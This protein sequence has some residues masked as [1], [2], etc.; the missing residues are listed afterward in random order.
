MAHVGLLAAVVLAWAVIFDMASALLR[1]RSSG[2]YA[3]LV[4]TILLVVLF[5][6]GIRMLGLVGRQHAQIQEMRARNLQAELDLLKAQVHPHFLFNTLN[7]L[8]GLAR[9]GAPAAADG[10]AQLRTCCAT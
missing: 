9:Q 6:T 8:F 1:A 7:N 2:Q 3:A 10:I 5:S 4:P